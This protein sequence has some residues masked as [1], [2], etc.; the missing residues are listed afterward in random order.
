MGLA[1]KNMDFYGVLGVMS[2]SDLLDQLEQTGLGV[3]IAV[4]TKGLSTLL[5]YS[6]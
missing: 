2:T 1:P 5:V 4:S 6:F 3:D